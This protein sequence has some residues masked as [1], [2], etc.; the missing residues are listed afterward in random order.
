LL[1]TLAA[2][3]VPQR[4]EDST[5]ELSTNQGV[6]ST[7]H[8][9]KTPEGAEMRLRLSD[10][11]RREQLRAETREQVRSVHPELAQV[12]GLDA[13]LESKLIDVL[14]DQQ[15]AHLEQLYSERPESPATYSARSRDPLEV[16]R[17]VADQETR[18]KQQIRD[19]LGEERFERYLSYTDTLRERSAVDYFNAHLNEK[20][21]LT[22]DQKERL[23]KLLR[24]QQDADMARRLAESGSRIPLAKSAISPEAMQKLNVVS[25]E[26]NFRQMQEEGH[27]LLRELPAILTPN[28]LEAYARMEAEKLSRQKKYVQ[29]LRVNAGMSSEFDDTRPRELPA[30]R[31]PVVGRVRLEIRLTADAGAPV[32]ADLF[33]EN[34]KTATVFQGPAGLWVEAT[35]TL[36]EDGWAQVD[37]TYYEE[38]RGQR[39]RVGGGMSGMQTRRPDGL[40]SYGGGGGTL[41]GGSKTYTMSTM[42]K[43]SAVE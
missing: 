2:Q 7:S 23:M 33:T 9:V 12:L 10:P 18:N 8:P 15:M 32:T 6:F 16:V 14:S 13:A 4:K 3:M 37:L 31:N 35:P 29:Q 36:Y 27:A 38:R 25:N 41:S 42:M 43:V 26:D 19:V 22:A 5:V 20:D 34:G 11:V 28:Q 1:G 30:K 21:R 39:Y 40:P 17:Q 24:A